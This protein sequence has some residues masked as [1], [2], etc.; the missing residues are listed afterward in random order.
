MLELPPVTL[1]AACVIETVSMVVM[2][3][4]FV[5]TRPPATLAVPTVTLPDAQESAMVAVLLPT[6]PPAMPLSPVRT[7]PVAKARVILPLLSPTRPP[8]ISHA[9]L[10]PPTLPVAQENDAPIAQTEAAVGGVVPVMVPALSPT[11]PPAKAT[12]SAVPATAPNAREAAM[13]EPCA[14]GPTRRPADQNT[15]VSVAAASPTDA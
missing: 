8:T 2:V 7:L 6:R 14:M 5:P 13:A 3:P 15:P 9:A 11:R 4:T 1:P 12:S 10:A